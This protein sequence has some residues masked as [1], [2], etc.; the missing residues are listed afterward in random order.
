[1][2]QLTIIINKSISLHDD[3][4]LINQLTKQLTLLLWARHVRK[5]IT[6]K[7]T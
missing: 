1:M 4:I 7:Q 6:Y 5:F 3:V 2:T